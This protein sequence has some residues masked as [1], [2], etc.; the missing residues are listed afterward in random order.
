MT[1]SSLSSFFGRYQRFPLSPDNIVFTI[2]TSPEDEKKIVDS[3]ESSDIA[4]SLS[5]HSKELFI[6]QSQQKGSRPP[7]IRQ[8][9]AF[10]IMINKILRSGK[11]VHFYTEVENLAA[12]VVYICCFSM[13]KNK[14]GADLTFAPFSLLSASLKPFQ[15][16]V[17]QK[18]GN[19]D[20]TVVSCLRSFEKAI[21]NK[22]YTFE[23]FSQE[24]YDY[25]DN[26][27][28][29]W[30]VP[31]VIITFWSKKQNIPQSKAFLA[32]NKLHI[33]HYVSLCG[34]Y[35]EKSVFYDYGFDYTEMKMDSSLPSFEIVGDFLELTS[36]DHTF[37]IHSHGETDLSYAF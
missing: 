18:Q 35:Y 14:Q 4:F 23:K 34:Q 26:I 30:I 27:H 25:F 9:H 8:I 21:N 28:M 3:Q 22:W 15:N 36:S 11:R 24:Q 32:F 33:N 7:S 1:R 5:S 19:G 12:S 2:V 17:L 29:N 10:V 20:V 31:D 13:L 16:N 6:D 37:V